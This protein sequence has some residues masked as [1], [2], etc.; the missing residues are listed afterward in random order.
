MLAIGKDFRLQR[1]ERPSRVDQ[2]DAGEMIVS[3][4]LL[5]AQVLLHGHGIVGAAFHRGVVGDDQALGPAHPAD[6]GDD[7]RG[8]RL[9]VV[10]V[11]CGQR[12]EL[13]KRRAGI[14]QAIDPI[15]HEQLSLLDVALAILR[16]PSFA[17]VGLPLAQLSHQ[18]AMVRL[19]FLECLGAGVESG[20]EDFHGRG[21]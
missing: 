14:E 2:V 13:Q 8:R 9:A 20:G 19:V 1:Q 16:P 5:S 11:P 18:P 21:V 15:A 3:R 12:A 17:D 10:Q 4:H 6:A 7:P